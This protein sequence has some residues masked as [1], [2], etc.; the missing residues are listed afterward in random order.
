VQALGIVGP[1]AVPKPWR[2]VRNRPSSANSETYTRNN[3]RTAGRTLYVKHFRGVPIELSGVEPD[4]ELV[5]TS[6]VVAVPPEPLATL[7]AE[8]GYLPCDVP[9]IKRILCTGAPRTRAASLPWLLPCRGNWDDA[10]SL[11]G[12]SSIQSV[13][14]IGRPAVNRHGPSSTRD[15]ATSLQT[16]SCSLSDQT[17]ASFLLPGPNPIRCYAQGRLRGGRATARLALDGR[18]GGIPVGVGTALRP[19]PGVNGLGPSRAGDRVG[20]H[21][22]G[23][24]D[25][26]A[27]PVPNEA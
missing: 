3:G 7:L 19:S 14:S 27:D 26:C 25:A 16:P 2:H 17:A 15:R 21:H 5:V 18:Y 13:I 9:L 23:E 24:A 12:R 20:A 6:P 1:D 11:D 8:R 10:A 22:P 4:H